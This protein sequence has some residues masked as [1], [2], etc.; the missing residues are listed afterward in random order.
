M[1]FLA[2]GPAAIVGVYTTAQGNLPHRSSFSAQLE[3]IK[4]ALDDAGLTPGDV[5]GLSP[6]TGTSHLAGTPA[7]M[8]WAEQLG[9]RPITIHV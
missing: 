7:A 2:Q 9:E 1:A 6:M 4:G 8:F 3:A 5:D